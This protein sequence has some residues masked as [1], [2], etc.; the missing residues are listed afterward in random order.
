M[1][2][3]EANFY[4][5]GRGNGR[6]GKMWSGT[7]GSGRERESRVYFVP[8]RDFSTSSRPRSLFQPSTVPTHGI[9]FPSRL[10]P[11]PS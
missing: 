2:V 7:E 9:L 6:V 1:A 5:G 3:G 10:F 4:K 11:F 8:D